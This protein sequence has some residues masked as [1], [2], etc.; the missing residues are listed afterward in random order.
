MAFPEE[1]KKCLKGCKVDNVEFKVDFSDELLQKPISEFLPEIVS[2]LTDNC[3]DKGAKSILITLSNNVLRVE[4]DVVESDPKK[5]LKLL[6]KIKN[7]GKIKTTKDKQREAA[8]CGLGGGM[9]ISKIV[10]GYLNKFGG[11]L[12]YF[13]VEGRIVAEATWQ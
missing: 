5:T 12:D 8:G 4:D 1:I 2:E 6:N 3:M 7:S 9:G 13:I 10:M 11:N